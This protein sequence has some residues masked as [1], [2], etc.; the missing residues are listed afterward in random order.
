MQKI[1]LFLVLGVSLTMCKNVEETPA[2]VET[3]VVE[4]ELKP[5]PEWSKNA[6]I[7]EVNVRQYTPEGTINAFEE[8]LP[9]LKE[10]GVDILWLM[11]IHPIGKEKRKGGLGSPYSIVDYKAFNQDYGT[12]AD[13]KN[14]VDKAH[15]MGFK[16]ILDWV[17][18]H[19]AFDA[20][21]MA[22]HKD[23][24]TKNENG[25]IIHPEGTDWYDVADLNFDNKEMRAAMIDALEYWVREFDIDGYRCDV[26]GSVPGDFWRAAIPELHEIKH[27]FMLA[28]ADEPW[29]HDVGFHM[30]Y[31]WGFHHLMNQVAQGKEAVSRID[32]FLLE[33]ATKYKPIDYR[34]NFITNHD[35][36]TWNGTVEERMGDLGDAMA[37]LSF[38]AQGMP[39][40]YSGQEAGLNKRLSFFEKDTVDF[41]DLS[42]SE[43]YAR[44]LKLK[45]ENPA[46]WNGTY[47]GDYKKIKTTADKSVFAYE[48][49]KGDNKVIVFLN[50]SDQRVSFER[51][52]DMVNA[53]LKD[54]FTGEEVDLDRLKN[55]TLEAG[56]YW[57][58]SND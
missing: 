23:W 22:D 4:K 46:I 48:R 24:Y 50:L 29:L 3:E 47:G 53:K 26:A 27:V 35:E 57:V 54:I 39:L 34:M 32:T 9:R 45:H 38:T 51:F 43:F 16:V 5:A 14:F 44:L 20:V 25:E 2:A 10:L 37:V 41:S 21:W 56:G 12:D 6:N 55:I 15:E 49:T 1:I 31:G 36:N 18:N 33:D 13:F 19:T 58:L 7:Y 30:S 11:P 28:E 40:I 17:A 42:K 8:H 52:H